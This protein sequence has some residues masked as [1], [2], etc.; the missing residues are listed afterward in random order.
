MP[1]RIKDEDGHRE[2]FSKMRYCW[3]SWFTIEASAEKRAHS[4]TR[5]RN[6]VQI[7]S[8]GRGGV[9]KRYRQN[10]LVALRLYRNPVDMDW[11]KPLGLDGGRNGL[12]DDLDGGRYAMVMVGAVV[13]NG[14]RLLHSITLE[15]SNGHWERG[16]CWSWEWDIEKAVL[17]TGPE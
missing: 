9:A 13:V 17:L 12:K 1:V 11:E 16:I 2:R 5:Y 6:W 4:R 3:W 14:S 10:R 8:A 15:A 7:D